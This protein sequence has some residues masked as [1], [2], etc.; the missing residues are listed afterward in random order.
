[1][2]QLKSKFLSLPAKERKQ[3]TIITFLGIFGCYGLVAAF[4]W[5]GMFEA[6]KMADRRANRIETRI[7]NYTPPKIDSFITPKQ[8][9]DAKQQL[10]SAEQR[11]I[12][13]SQRLL[14]LD[15]PEPRENLKLEV[16]RL[17]SHHLIKVTQLS[18]INDQIRPL[19]SELNGQALRDIF[20]KRPLFKIQGQGNFYN[21]ISFVEGLNT[22]TY[23]SFTPQFTIERSEDPSLSNELLFNLELQM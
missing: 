14:P 19:P 7:G 20:D 4:L 13:F 15:N 1:M 16:T 11:L 21:F 2:L 22:L 17:A 12:E 6:K 8:L 5:E 3:I 9:S 23:R 10:V 18:V